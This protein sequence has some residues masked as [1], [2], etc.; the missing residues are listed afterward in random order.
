MKQREVI[1][2]L[3]GFLRPFSG[4]ILLSITLSMLTIGS[5]IALM[6]TSAWLISTA[7][8]QLGITSLGVAPTMVRFFG[9][10]R[11]V[12][13][14]LER[15]VSHDV[16]FRLLA[17]L[18]VWFYERLEPLAPAGLV[19]YRSGD[20]M[21][22]VVS[23]V[24]ELQNF[25]IRVVAPPL[26]A[27]GVVLVTTLVVMMFDFW[28]GLALFGFMLAAGTLL[29]FLTWWQSRHPGRELVQSR[30]ELNT[31]LVDMIQGAADSRAYG[32]TAVQQAQFKQINDQI[33]RQEAYL[34][35]IDGVQT[36]LSVLLANLA[37]L[38]V[39]V[40]AIPRVEG[41]Y[42]AMLA[43]GT[44]AAFEALMPL[45]VAAT[46]LSS[47]LTAAE[48]LLELS[49]TPNPVT[50]T[51]TYTDIPAAPSLSI[52][53]LTFRYGPHLSPVLENFSLHITPG[54]RVAIIGESGAGKSTLVN[55]LLR[56]WDYDSGH[57]TIGDK[58]LREFEAQTVHRIFGVMSQRTHLF[59]T[60]IMENIRIANIDAPDEAV[61]KAAKQAQIHEFIQALPDGY[62]TFV[63]EDGALL[64]G[65][66]RQRIALARVILKN[67]PI[68]I[69]DE[70]TANLDAE[71]ENEVIQA[72]DRATVGRT[73][74]YITHR[75]PRLSSLRVVKVER[76]PHHDL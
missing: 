1:G 11:A 40:I 3:F 31:L 75:K 38:V 36:G 5:S 22:R 69:L 67:A 34:S 46:H 57:I 25:F 53:N 56:Y 71:T 21:A 10:S 8:L 18:R 60:T 32:H 37:A 39:L 54:E 23:D 52:T 55:V 74:L 12:F 9:I 68:W 50:H 2:R 4:R 41:V 15:L 14:Y 72:I 26:T 58:E 17:R 6:M 70:A 61:I 44:I 47:E 30:A 64:S 65:G 20:L 45:S 28:A 66:E 27:L 73:V 62:D 42:L 59:N 33:T 13:R 24:E 63:G 43:L 49:R 48:R 7:G 76:V 35:R 29:P 16:T 51:G 19:Q